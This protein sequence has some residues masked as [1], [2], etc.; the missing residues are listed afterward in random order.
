MTCDIKNV[1]RV[2][3]QMSHTVDVVCDMWHLYK[4]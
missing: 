1:A 3:Q 4:Y 2:T